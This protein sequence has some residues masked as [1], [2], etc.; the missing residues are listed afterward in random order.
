MEQSVAFCGRCTSTQRR[1]NKTILQKPQESFQACAFSGIYARTQSNGTVLEACQEIFVK[2]ASENNAC[3]RISPEKNFQEERLYAQN[4]PLF[5]R[6]AIS[7]T[8]SAVNIT[9]NMIDNKFR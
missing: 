4:V 2:Q 5:K 8:G 6:L 9:D 1:K 7:D 3:C